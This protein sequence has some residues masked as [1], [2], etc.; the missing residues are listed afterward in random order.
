M[1]VIIILL[2]FDTIM[3]MIV[4]KFSLWWIVALITRALFCCRAIGATFKV[5][6][7]AIAEGVDIGFMILFHIIFKGSG[8]PWGRTLL[9]IGFTILA[10]FLEFLDDWLFVYTIEDVEDDE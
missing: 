7:L 10:L 6:N 3:Q 1:S 5:K 4:C 8:F 9:F 2:V